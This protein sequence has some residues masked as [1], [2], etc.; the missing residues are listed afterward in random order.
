MLAAVP[1]L[2][3]YW[4]CLPG[5]M[6]LWLAQNSAPSA[7]LFVAAHLAP[8]ALVD[9]AFYQEVKLALNVH[10]LEKLSKH[11]FIVLV[12]GVLTLT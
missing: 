9:A 11:S 7:L 4:V 12:L 10:H 2:A 8:M 1:F 6:E 3:P 5:A